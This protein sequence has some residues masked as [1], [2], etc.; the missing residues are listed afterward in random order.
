MDRSPRELDPR[1]PVPID[2]AKLRSALRRL[3]DEYV[4]YML[5]DAIELLPETALAN[6]AAGYL[7]VQ[8][9]RPDVPKA[10]QADLLN[11]GSPVSWQMRESSF[12]LFRRSDI[13]L[14]MATPQSIRIM[15][16]GNHAP[17]APRVSVAAGRAMKSIL[18]AV[19]D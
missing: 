11:T 18:S 14:M 4:Y 19:S 10:E 5:D 16:S 12:A 15:I 7:D 6:L 9:L 8:R 3:G 2:R 17:A 1:D 13:G